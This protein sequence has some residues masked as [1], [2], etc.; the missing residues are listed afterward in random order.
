M[1]PDAE[2]SSAALAVV[3]LAVVV[4]GLLDGSSQG[5][6]FG[7][8]SDLPPQYTHVRDWPPLLPVEWLKAPF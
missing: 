3:L 4:V 7:D 8:A 2:G 6:I 1:G 5:A